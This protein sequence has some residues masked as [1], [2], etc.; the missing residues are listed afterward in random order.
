MVFFTSLYGRS[1]RWLA[2]LVLWLGFAMI[3]LAVG[4][5][6]CHQRASYANDR[7]STNQIPVAP[8]ASFA[9]DTN[10]APAVA[11][12]ASEPATNTAPPEP[13]A[14]AVPA[15]STPT[16]FRQ[17]APMPKPEVATA[18]LSPAFS[19]SPALL[20][21]GSLGGFRALPV[22]AD[23]GEK[24]RTYLDAAVAGRVYRADRLLGGGF[25]GAGRRHRRHPRRAVT[26]PASGAERA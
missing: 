18:A 7:R 6:E 21:L 17:P 11:T 24:L 25:R 9:P 19:F 1:C 4:A 5:D 12:P 15:T 14:G 13:A 8:I 20:A 26:E 10:A 2:I 22:R 16:A 23:A 3:G